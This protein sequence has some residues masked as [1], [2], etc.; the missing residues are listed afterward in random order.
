MPA[1]PR[2]AKPARQ[3]YFLA[4][5]IIPGRRGASAVSTGTDE[6]ARHGT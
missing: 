2:I 3:E 4:D 5:R 1:M 6:A